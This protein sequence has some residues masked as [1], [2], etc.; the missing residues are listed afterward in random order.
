MVNFNTI[1]QEVEDDKLTRDKMEEDE[2]NPYQK[3]GLN[4]VYREDIKTAQLEH[5]SVLSDV[6]K[7]FQHDKDPKTLYD[8]NVKAPRLQ[9]SQEII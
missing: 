3:V 8:L 4:N 7:Y 6:V 1:K 2:I 5:W 9:K